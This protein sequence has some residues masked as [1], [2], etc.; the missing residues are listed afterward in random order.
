MTIGR[1]NKGMEEDSNRA[2]VFPVCIYGSD[3]RQ[4]SFCKYSELYA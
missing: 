2:P 4:N 3:F 1:Q